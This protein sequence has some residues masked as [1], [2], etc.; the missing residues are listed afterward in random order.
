MQ[1]DPEVFTHAT[2]YDIFNRMYDVLPTQPSTL[3]RH[4]SQRQSFFHRYGFRDLRNIQCT[5]DQMCLHGRIN[6]YTF[7]YHVL[8]VVT[9]IFIKKLI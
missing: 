3:T 8:I 7:V 4:V 6:K 5:L 9:F 2:A 1:T